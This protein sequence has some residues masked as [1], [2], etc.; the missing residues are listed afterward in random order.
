MP[1][2]AVC[3][4]WVNNCRATSREARPLYPR[5]RTPTVAAGMS[6]MGHKRTHAVQ[7]SM[8]G[9][10]GQVLTDFRQEF[11]RAEGLRHIV[12]TARRPRLLFLAAEGVRGDGDDRDRAQR[13]IGFNPACGG[14]TVHNRHL[15]I[16]QDKIRPLFRDSCQCLLTIFG[17]GDLIVCGGKHIVN[18]LATI[19]LV[20]DH[21]NALAHAASTCR[22][23]ITG[24]LN[25]NVEPWPGCNSTQILPPCISTMRLDIASPKPVPPFFLVM[26][27]SACWNSWNSLAWSAAEMPG[28]VSRTDT[29]NEPLF[30]S[31]LMATSPASVNLMALPTRLIRTC[32]KRRPSPW[33]GGKLGAS[34]SLNA[35]FL[36]AAS[37]SSVLRTVWAMS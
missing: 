30:A 25:A 10:F 5:K 24:R 21:Q 20:L 13:R 34:S 15:D 17:R 14:V 4:L 37:G 8:C 27:L 28:P 2:R 12:I 36:S 6:A 26:A 9:L 1:M 35:S 11:T 23:T 16:H 22:S 32:V 33:P 18:D 19:R 3:P 29:W 7:Q 31:A